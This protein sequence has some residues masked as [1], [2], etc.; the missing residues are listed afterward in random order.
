MGNKL[1]LILFYFVIIFTGGAW[2]GYSNSDI[3][4]F[5][6]NNCSQN[7]DDHNQVVYDKECIEKMNKRVNAC[8]SSGG[9]IVVANLKDR[10]FCKLAAG[11]CYDNEN[12]KVIQN[13][14]VDGNRCKAVSQNTSSEK[15]CPTNSTKQLHDNPTK[16][17][18]KEIHCVCTYKDTSARDGG[19]FSLERDSAGRTCPSGNNEKASASSEF[20]CASL[21]TLSDRISKCEIT[22]DKLVNTCDSKSQENAQYTQPAKQ[23]ITAASQ[24][25]ANALINKSAL[26]TCQK[27]AAATATGAY[28]FNYIKTN[29]ENEKKTCLSSCSDILQVKNYSQIMSMC[30]QTN[31]TVDQKQSLEEESQ[32]LYSQIKEIGNECDG[33]QQSKVKE[34][35]NILGSAVNANMQANQQAVECQKQID[36]TV[37]ANPITEICLK[38]P[39]DPRCPVD[40]AV[41]R[42][43]P[44]CFCLF[45]PQDAKCNGGANPT[46]NVNNQNPRLNGLA[47]VPGY[48]AGGKVGG[49]LSGLGVGSGIGKL[50]MNLK[51]G[52][53][54]LNPPV[55][56]AGDDKAKPMFEAA[57]GGGAGGGGS[58]GGS[59]GQDPNAKKKGE[60]EPEDKGIGGLFK[61]V[62]NT[63]GNFF[64]GGS[65]HKN[66]SG[67]DSKNSGFNSASFKKKE[68]NLAG[69]DVASNV[70]CYTD[71]KG[72]RVCLSN[73][74]NG[75]IFKQANEGYNRNIR[76]FIGM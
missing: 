33:I 1:T 24:A 40:C 28:N 17:G 12:D 69:R 74:K 66:Y 41:D 13:S 15:Q 61:A 37:V 46:T 68:N 51:N 16:P 63:V 58:G 2:G 8:K 4:G 35:I 43:H 65:G 48:S 19:D 11:S 22:K 64:G 59:A 56:P 71:A 72:Q 20:T 52:A 42:Q 55:G 76:S 32:D 70:R 45:N 57:Q 21:Q 31:F 34:S 29:C 49:E 73:Q 23:V 50:D 25:G 38:N 44:N 14:E 3:E 7:S 26:S 18:E 62:K 10:N 5:I 67:S 60:P 30:D 39:R 36:S 75:D 47:T 9:E 6:D 27:M 53:A 54:A